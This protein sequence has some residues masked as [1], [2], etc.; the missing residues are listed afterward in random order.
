M[1]LQ[2]SNNE[3]V[4]MVLDVGT[5]QGT[6]VILISEDVHHVVGID[7]SSNALRIARALLLTKTERKNISFV[8]GD[9]E[10]L[11]FKEDVFDIA[12]CKDVLHHVSNSLMTVLEMK[13]VTIVGGRVIAVEANACNPQMIIIGLMYF[14]VDKGVFKNTKKRLFNLFIKAGLANVQVTETE[15]LPRHTLFEYRSPIN[16]VFAPNSQTVVR[17][18]KKIESNWQRRSILRSFLNYLMISGLKGK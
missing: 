15:F 12:Y 9:A 18:L 10:H 1:M 13:R 5:G 7:L 17:I 4:K 3:K 6:D 8:V 2:S 11:P 14:Y 16:R